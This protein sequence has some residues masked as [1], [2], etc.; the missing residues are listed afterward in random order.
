MLRGGAGVICYGCTACFTWRIQPGSWAVNL[1][2]LSKKK[3]VTQ[4]TDQC[5]GSGLSA[6]SEDMIYSSE[7][8][9]QS[10]SVV[11]NSRA[12]L[13]MSAPPFFCCIAL[14]E[15]EAANKKHRKVK[16]LYRSF[17]LISCL[18]RSVRCFQP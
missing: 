2:R 5:C 13:L 15:W 14:N 1:Q 18:R 16:P 9:Q 6:F 10:K 4:Q 12:L 7:L 8:G 17:S 3:H 11:D